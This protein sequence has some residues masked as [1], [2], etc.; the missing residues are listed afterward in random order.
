MFFFFKVKNAN[1]PQIFRLFTSFTQSR[2]PNNKT[3][4]D[5]LEKEKKDK[6]LYMPGPFHWF[7]TVYV[8]K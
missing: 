8:E 4:A 5:N 1:S 2:E 7:R 3:T 6:I